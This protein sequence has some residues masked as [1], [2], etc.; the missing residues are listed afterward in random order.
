MAA[1]FVQKVLSR[2]QRE[3]AKVKAR[4]AGLE[5]GSDMRLYGSPIVE[6]HPGS[7]ITLGHG[8][9]LVSDARFTALGVSRPTILRTLAPGA[10]L[11]IGDGSGLSGT[12]ICAAVSV[13]IGERVLIGADVMIVDTDFHPVDSIPRTGLPVPEG[14][15]QDAVRIGHD[16]FLGGRSI[17]LKGVTVGDGAVVGAGSVVTSDVAPHTIVAGN[18]A[19]LVRETR[20]PR[21]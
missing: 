12:T 5:H 7:R 15:P 17:I 18:P 3:T 13:V 14:R 11:T 1:S 2:V 20:T 8:V 19:R 21:S 6:L 10:H 4:R 16:V 9:T